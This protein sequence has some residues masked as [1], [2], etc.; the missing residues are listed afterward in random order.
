VISRLSQKRDEDSELATIRAYLNT[1]IKEEGPS[2]NLDEL[3]TLHTEPFLE[4]GEQLL[5]GGENSPHDLPLL[6]DYLRLFSKI[7]PAEDIQPHVGQLIKRAVSR[8]LD[9]PDT[10]QS[11]LEAPPIPRT[12]KHTEP[13]LN[14]TKCVE[15]QLRSWSRRRA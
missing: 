3:M 5:V 2:L 12:R 13:F 4:T 14:C 8:L 1:P 7:I 10:A 6:R 11:E 9:D 15:L